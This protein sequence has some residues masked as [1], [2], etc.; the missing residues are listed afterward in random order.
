M[1]KTLLSTLL[2]V[3][4]ISAC[5]TPVSKI[6]NR[7]INNS[8]SPQEYYAEIQKAITLQ[9]YEADKYKG[10]RCEIAFQ[11]DK[12][13]LVFMIDKGNGYAPLCE[14]GTIAIK[15]AKIPAPP[16]DK[17]YQMFKHSIVEFAPN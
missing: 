7:S 11:M 9:M 6:D 3:M 17:L 14:Q 15:Q 2:P 5:T 8:I 4:F 16:S 13:G 1:G 12:T 10:E